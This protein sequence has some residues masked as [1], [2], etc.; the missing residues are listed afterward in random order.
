MVTAKVSPVAN[1]AIKEIVILEYVCAT[2]TRTAT[3]IRCEA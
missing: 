3:R 2:T 1:E